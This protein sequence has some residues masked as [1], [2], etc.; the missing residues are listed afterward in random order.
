VPTCKGAWCPQCVCLGPERWRCVCCPHTEV[1]AID[2]ATAAT[3]RWMGGTRS[4]G[5]G[6]VGEWMAL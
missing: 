1:V 6:P 3:H 5:V 4:R 2:A